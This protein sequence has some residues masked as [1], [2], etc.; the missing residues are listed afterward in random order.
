MNCLVVI[1]R[2]GYEILR[3]LDN[4]RHR[5]RRLFIVSGGASR[6]TAHLKTS[7]LSMIQ[8]GQAKRATVVWR[9]EL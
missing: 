9:L 5:A 1:Q 3:R 4:L 7:K 8:I 6:L 2:L